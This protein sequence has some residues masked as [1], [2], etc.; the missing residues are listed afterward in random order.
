MI[1]FYQ[2]LTLKLVKFTKGNAYI[3]Y[4]FIV[5]YLEMRIRLNLVALRT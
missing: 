2:C 3:V 4:A 5:E 1:V